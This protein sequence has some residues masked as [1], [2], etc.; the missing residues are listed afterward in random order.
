MMKIDILPYQRLGNMHVNIERSKGKGILNFICSKNEIILVLLGFFLGRS[1]MVGGIMPFGMAA[2]A[3]SIGLNVNR[4]FMAIA[5]LLGMITSGASYQTY[6]ALVAMVLFNAFNMSFRNIRSKITFKIAIMASISIFIPEMVFTYLQ[7]FLLYDLLKSLFHGLVVFSAVFIFRNALPIITGVRKSAIL[8]HEELISIAVVTAL[9]LSG[10]SN[11][12]IFGFNIKNVLCILIIMA[13]SYRCGSGVGSAIGVTVGLII[14]M[15][16]NINPLVLGAY[17]FCGLLAGVFRNLGKIGSCLGFVMGNTI[18]TIYLSGSIDALIYLKEIVLSAFIFILIPQKSIDILAYIFGSDV[19]ANGDKR[20]YSSR[21]KEITVDKLDKFSRTFKELSKTFSEISETKVVADKQDIS[22]IIDRVADNVCKDCSLCLHCWDRNFYDTYQVMF[23]MLEKLDVK[24]RIYEDDIPDYFIDKC[25]RILDFVKAINSAYEVFKVDMVWKNR[26][27]E[28]RELVSQQL[29]G[30]SNVISNLATEINTDIHFKADLED[31]ILNELSNN[32][33]KA[34]DVIVFENKWNKYEVS[35]FHRGCGGKR[36]CIS[37]IEKIVSQVVGKKMVKEE[38]ECQQKLKNNLCTLKLVEEET[39]KVTTGVAKVAKHGGTISGDSY[40]FMNTGDGKYIVAISDG[41][42]SGQK[43]ATQ[44]K[45][46]INLL[47]Q[48]MESGFDKETTVK[49]INSILVLKSSED[50]FTTIDLSIIDLY[51]GEVEFVKIGAVPT[52]IKHSEKI[53]TIKSVSLPAGILSN[54]EVE[55]VHKKVNS[56]DFLIMMSDGVVDSFNV[57][58]DGDKKLGDI[59]NEIKSINPQEIADIILDKAYE[60]CE[61]KP[62]DDM[63]VVV[64]K[65]WKP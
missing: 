19:K 65:I 48:F 43:A 7:G 44:S 57:K 36:A 5:V 40:T 25:E 11:I 9:A 13:F 52:Y 64:A 23:K 27:G 30:L 53:D 4:V 39:F 45:A 62:V 29:E 8:S 21:I 20:S 2:Y 51:K 32:G 3:A 16:G 31:L 54:V 14:S 26:I 61:A 37:S 10:L 17:A 60:N 6:I 18:L 22:S 63:M 50:S 59:L 24:G 33:V 1:T 34:T 55:L 47:E 38:T 49:L 58:E 56:G 41:M 28:S 46:T 35:I 42:G 12:M 15:S